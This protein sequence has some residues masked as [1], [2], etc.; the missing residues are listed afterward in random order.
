MMQ[1]VH[2][3]LGLYDNPMLIADEAEKAGIIT[4]FITNS[5]SEF[6]CFYLNFRYFRWVRLALGLHP[7]EAQRHRQYYSMF[8]RLL[9]KTSFVGEVGL[10]FSLYG[11][12]TKDRQLES[13]RFVLSCIKDQVKV[14]SVHS[15]SA[16]SMV[17][18]LL[19]EYGIKNVIFH[20][21][22]GSL[23]TLENIIEQGYY[24]SIN[25]AMT[26]SSKG[27]SI[28]KAIPKSK[29]LLETDGPFIKIKG[30]P[31]RP[32]DTNQLIS[33][34]QDIWQDPYEQVIKQLRENFETLIYP[35]RQTKKS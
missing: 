26:K 34:L 13:F 35:L 21:Y 6:E 8:Q 7:L 14:I 9:P 4:L 23:K 27:L 5:P 31:I 3:H 20:W 15:R 11:K 16:E 32:I 19:K 22:S 28:I 12:A 2:C 18:D 1:D 29:T 25:D 24:F 33:K 17:L 30:R 10:D